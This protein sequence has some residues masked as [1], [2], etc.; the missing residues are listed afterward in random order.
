[1]A[2]KWD[3][4]FTG[5]AEFNTTVSK[6][7]SHLEENKLSA[8]FLYAILLRIIIFSAIIVCA[9]VD[10][11]LVTAAVWVQHRLRVPSWGSFP[12][13]HTKRTPIIATSH[14]IQ[15]LDAETSQHPTTLWLIPICLAC[16]QF[17]LMTNM[18]FSRSNFA[19]KGRCHLRNE[20]IDLKNTTVS[21]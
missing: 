16:V 17:Y 21:I 7:V 1:M 11:D 18:S 4:S 19:K 3:S 15:C 10:R 14:C 20:P 8:R 5:L 9:C 6:S 2:C 12:S 13:M